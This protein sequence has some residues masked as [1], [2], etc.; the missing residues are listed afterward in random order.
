MIVPSSIKQWE[1]LSQSGTGGNNTLEAE[2]TVLVVGTGRCRAAC[3]RWLWMHPGSLPLSDSSKSDTEEG[4][5]NPELQRSWFLDNHP[6]KTGSRMSCNEDAHSTDD[7]VNQNRTSTH[8][9][10]QPGRYW[11]DRR[12]R[13]LCANAKKTFKIDRRISGKE[14]SWCSMP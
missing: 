7:L 8:T 6:K 1:V 11:V 9:F 13:Q 4:G 3:S 5:G 2:E 10:C 12:I 14:D